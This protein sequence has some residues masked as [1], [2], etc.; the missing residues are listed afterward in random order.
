MPVRSL[1]SPVLKWPDF[2]EVEQA[3]RT[4]VKS[5]VR[6]HPDILRIGYFGSYARG[7]WSVGSDLDVILI[8]EECEAPFERRA[9]DWDFIT[10][11]VPVDVLVYSEQEWEGLAAIGGRFRQATQEEAVWIF[12][13]KNHQS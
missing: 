12:D 13:R 5:Q 3:L 2:V 1:S 10:L 6:N 9:L 7:D 8:L 4:W 11:P